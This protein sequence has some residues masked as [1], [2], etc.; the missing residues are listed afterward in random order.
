[1]EKSV[2]VHRKTNQITVKI[3]MTYDEFQDLRSF[4]NVV[5]KGKEWSTFNELWSDIPMKFREML[6]KDDF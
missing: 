6:L 2:E 3:N 1:M 5:S 4:M